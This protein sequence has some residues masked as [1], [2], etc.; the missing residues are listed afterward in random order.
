L[1]M[2]E[3]HRF[4]STWP[5]S[6]SSQK[7]PG[8]DEPASPA[9]V[10]ESGGVNGGPSVAPESG[11]GVPSTSTLPAGPSS[12]A[13]PGAAMLASPASNAPVPG[14]PP[15]PLSAV[16]AP[17]V[18]PELSQPIDEHP[19]A[20]SNQPRRALFDFIYVL[21][22][23]GLTLIAETR[24]PAPS[25]RPAATRNQQ[26]LHWF[27]SSKVR[28]LA[29]QWTEQSRSIKNIDPN[30]DDAAMPGAKCESLW[31]RWNGSCAAR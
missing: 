18:G 30:L 6:K 17:V 5:S 8:H 22:V 24:F 26:I 28:D 23:A 14:L 19:H 9:G 12:P 21:L 31:P 13:L 1:I 16:G 2:Y 7:R 15:V 4:A 10:L 3:T 25:A 27:T 11:G 20:I 29:S